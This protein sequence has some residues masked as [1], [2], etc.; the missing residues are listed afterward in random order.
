MTTDTL[1][2]KIVTGLVVAAALGAVCV[3]GPLRQTRLTAEVSRP[4]QCTKVGSFKWDCNT[5]SCT[6]T[7]NGK[8]MQACTLKACVHR[9]TGGKGPP[10]KKVN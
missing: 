1:S 9:P 10:T 2:L 5:C 4:P 8:F 6:K 3:A 7:K